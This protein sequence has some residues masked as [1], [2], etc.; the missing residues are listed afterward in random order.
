MKSEKSISKTNII[1]IIIIIILHHQ[2]A[3]AHSVT[4]LLTTKPMKGCIFTDQGF[5]K[6]A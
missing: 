1:I 5:N 6:P 3:L 4:T 2:K